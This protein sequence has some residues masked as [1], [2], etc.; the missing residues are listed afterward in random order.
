MRIGCGL[1][2]VV[3]FGLGVI[4]GFALGSIINESQPEEMNMGRTLTAN[5]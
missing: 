2:G 1:A 4:S 5:A 3:H